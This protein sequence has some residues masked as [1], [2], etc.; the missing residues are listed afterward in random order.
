ML[1]IFTVGK[2]FQACNNEV[3]RVISSTYGMDSTDI[4]SGDCLNLMLIVQRQFF[5][6]FHNYRKQDFRVCCVTLKELLFMY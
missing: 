4:L 1:F 6:L 3:A 5:I 2:E